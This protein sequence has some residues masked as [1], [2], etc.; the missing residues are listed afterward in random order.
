M[1]AMNKNTK[2]IQIYQWGY[3]GS[4]W[5]Y[6][7]MRAALEAVNGVMVDVRFSPYSRAKKWQ[8]VSFQAGLK[9]RYVHVKAWGNKNY[10]EW[11]KPVKL[12]N[13]KQGVREVGDYIQ[14]GGYDGVVVMCGCSGYGGC[15]RQDVVNGLV[16]VKAGVFM[17][18]LVRV[19]REG[20]GE[21][22]NLFEDLDFLGR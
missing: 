4:G 19:V 6:D 11:G 22:L 12:V 7:E 16:R 17:G 5:A 21:Q 8:Q 15:H 1:G 20:D 9:E 13:F 18:E 10:R 3:S 14:F 2:P